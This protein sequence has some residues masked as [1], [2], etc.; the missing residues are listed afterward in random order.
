M[1]WKRWHQP[2]KGHCCQKEAFLVAWARLHKFPVRPRDTVGQEVAWQGLTGAWQRP[3]RSRTLPCPPQ[4]S[5]TW[6]AGTWCGG[7]PR[8]RPL[9]HSSRRSLCAFSGSSCGLSQVSY[10]RCTKVEHFSSKN[11]FEKHI[12][13]WKTVLFACEI[14]RHSCLLFVYI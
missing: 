14:S 12:L 5:C 9:L 10:S 11:N 8:H 4:G 1:G 6:T 2:R 13:T 3:F 7:A